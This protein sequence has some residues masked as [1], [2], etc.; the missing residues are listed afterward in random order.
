M[1]TS[2]R[3]ALMHPTERYFEGCGAVGS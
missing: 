2:E 3:E 1:I